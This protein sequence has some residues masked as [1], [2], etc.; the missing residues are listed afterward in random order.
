MEKMLTVRETAEL[1]H[2]HEKTVLRY[3]NSGQ[4]AG[5]KIGKHW[6]IRESEIEKI[7]G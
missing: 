3:L 1:L 4:I 6:L 7:I 2:L 5:K